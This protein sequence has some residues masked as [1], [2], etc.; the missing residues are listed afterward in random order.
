MM[1]KVY[2]IYVVYEGTLRFYP[3]IYKNLEDA[4]ENVEKWNLDEKDPKVLYAIKEF[5]MNE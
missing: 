2:A 4:K 3:I 5:D 1:I